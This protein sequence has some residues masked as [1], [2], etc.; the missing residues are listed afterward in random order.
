M[1]ILAPWG[2]NAFITFGALYY[3]VPKISGRPLYS[4][5]LANWHFALAIIGVMLYILSMWGAGV[6]QG[7]LWLNLDENGEIKYSFIDIM[8]AIAPYYAVRLLGGVL[9]LLGAL[10][11]AWNFLATAFDGGKKS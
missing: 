8:R 7:L 9:F 5:R 4:I 11:M 1:F 6:T 10:L 3:L 2:G